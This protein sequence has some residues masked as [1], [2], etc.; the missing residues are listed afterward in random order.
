MSDYLDPP[1][2]HQPEEDEGSLV[3]PLLLLLPLAAGSN[4]VSSSME[5]GKL[6]LD[7]GIE[8]GLLLLEVLLVLS[9]LDGERVN[10]PAVGGA[11][12]SKAPAAA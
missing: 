11:V 1:N 4:I 8:K 3:E 9:P 7:Q 6:L 5:D 12:G 2:D 10:P